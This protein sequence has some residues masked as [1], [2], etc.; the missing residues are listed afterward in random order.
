MTVSNEGFV[1]IMTSKE[2]PRALKL[3]VTPDDPMSGGLDVEQAETSEARTLLQLMQ[4]FPS[5]KLF[6]LGTL[7]AI[8]YLRGKVQE[9]ACTI[10]R[11]S[12]LISPCRVSRLIKA[13]TG[14][15]VKNCC[16]ELAPMREFFCRGL[17]SATLIASRYRS[18]PCRV[19]TS[20]GIF[21]T[22]LSEPL[23][24]Y[25]WAAVST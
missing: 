20:P 17:L 24:T 23:W 8:S 18:L 2:S 10:P 22:T 4:V 16:T 1:A 3:V 9:E 5:F 6:C 21:L 13:K 19:S 14:V 11:G 12:V 15:G 25:P 7:I